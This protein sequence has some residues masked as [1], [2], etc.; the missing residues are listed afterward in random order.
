MFFHPIWSQPP[1]LFHWQNALPLSSTRPP[2][3]RKPCLVDLCLSC[4]PFIEQRMKLK[5][6]ADFLAAPGPVQIVILFLCLSK[7]GGEQ[8]EGGIELTAWLWC[9]CLITQLTLS[10]YFTS[11]L[12]QCT[13]SSP[14]FHLLHPL[15]WDTHTHVHKLTLHTPF[16]HVSLSLPSY[17]HTH[18]QIITAHLW[19]L[20]QVS[21]L[22]LI[23]LL[24]AEHNHRDPQDL[25]LALWLSSPRWRSLW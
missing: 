8:R 6:R 18:T 14:P 3:L 2:C 22:I 19:P 16:P 12:Q 23:S 5:G 7:R 21:V 10:I 15:S 13:P 1:Y 11:T 25:Q 20:Y 17:T 24:N 9:S 4:V